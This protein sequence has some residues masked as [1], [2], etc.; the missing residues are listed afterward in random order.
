MKTVLIT[1]AS[2]GIGKACA[3]YFAKNGWRVV[4]NYNNSEAAANELATSINKSGGEAYTFKAD[5]GSTDE[6]RALVEYAVTFHT[7]HDTQSNRRRKNASEYSRQNRRLFHRFRQ[8]LTHRRH[9]PLPSGNICICLCL[10]K[11]ASR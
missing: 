2:R 3:E 6:C 7:E 5:V 4:I 11:G 8:N 1:G 10:R 9:P